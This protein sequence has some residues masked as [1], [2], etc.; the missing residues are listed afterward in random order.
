VLLLTSCQA[1]VG[2]R[3]D[4]HGDGSGAVRVTLTLDK[5]AADAV[6]QRVP[7]LASQLRKSD[8]TQ[9]GWTV[10]GPKAGRDGS[11]VLTATRSFANPGQLSAVMAEL[12][13]PTGP[14]QSFKLTRTASFA[15]VR[16]R[17]SGSVDL[18]NGLNGFGDPVLHQQLGGSDIGVDPA[19]VQQRLGVALDKVFG[20]NVS[21]RLPGKTMLW[22]PVVGQ[23]IDLVATS[24]QMRV[25]NLLFAGISLTAAFGFVALLIVR[26]RQGPS[27]SVNGETPSTSTY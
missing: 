23:R 13:G 25:P 9:S 22:T 2:V 11:Q 21:A 18:R 14:F 12:S 10:T 8:L 26:S 15:T 5:E 24:S 7:D 6:R 16:T 3:V 17:F 19:Q 20:F 27:V 1:T 4:A